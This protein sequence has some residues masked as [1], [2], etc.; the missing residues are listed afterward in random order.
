MLGLFGGTFDPIHYGHL[1][2]AWQAYQTLGLRQLRLMPCHLPPHRAAS[3]ASS[4]QRLMMLKLAIQNIPEFVIDEREL[5]SED[6]SYT[7]N[8]LTQIREEI[9]DEPLCLLVGL[10][11]QLASWHQ[12]EKLIQLAH[13]VFVNRPEHALVRNAFFDSLLKKEVQ[14]PA[15]LA[16]S[17]QGLVYFL[18][19]PTLTISSTLIRNLYAQEQSPRFL[20]PDAVLDYINT[21]QLYE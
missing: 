5:H 13:L 10:D 7:V 1:S 4:R 18:N 11:N 2:A 15:Q 19:N 12:P 8:S 14:D 9:G 6:L 3:K 20:L 16:H 21:E 17:P